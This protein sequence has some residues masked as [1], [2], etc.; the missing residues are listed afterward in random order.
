MRAIVRV[1]K[2]KGEWL[3]WWVFGEGIKLQADTPDKEAVFCNMATEAKY[4]KPRTKSERATIPFKAFLSALL[5]MVRDSGEMR[6]KEKTMQVSGTTIIQ[7]AVQIEVDDIEL[8]VNENVH[9]RWNAE[10]HGKMGRWRPMRFC[11]YRTFG[12][13]VDVTGKYVSEGR[14]S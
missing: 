10:H 13:W 5:N 12:R 7:R 8:E 3:A 2:F 11:Y 1:R 4:Q 6:E 9:P 14:P